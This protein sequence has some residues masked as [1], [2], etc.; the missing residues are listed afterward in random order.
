LQGKR[1]QKRQHLK[2]AI[3]EYLSKKPASFKDMMV[4]TALS[5]IVFA[6]SALFDIFNKIISLVYRHD[7]WQLDELFTVSVY[8]VFAIAL[9]ARRRHRELV[10]EIRRR[11]E[12]EEERA[13][14]IP[15]LESAL[16]DV[17]RLKKLLP[18]C[19]SCKRV[20]DDKG[21]WSQVEDYVETH[22]PARFDD[23]LCPDCTKMLIGNGHGFQRGR[24]V[25]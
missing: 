15:E 9:Y 22:F 8:L 11:Q 16:A 23:G 12:A 4:I 1:K 6:C 2:N 7:T 14:L 24:S 13:R 17:F 25:A 20:R 5:V 19:S 10:V 18:I 3:R 21:Y